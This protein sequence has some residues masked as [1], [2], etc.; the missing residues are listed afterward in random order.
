MLKVGSEDAFER[1]YTQRFREFAGRF[2]EFV[3]YERDR[4]ARDI[5]LHL[6]H[7]RADGEVL[8]TA[9][10]WFQLKGITKQK[11]SRESFDRSTQ[12]TV[13]LKVR[14]LKYWY[15]QPMPTFLSLY[16]ESADLF[17]VLNLQ[18]Y[19]EERWGRS[20]LQL[21]QEVAS[22]KVPRGSV[23]DSQAFHLILMENDVKAWARALAQDEESTRLCRRDYRLI[24]HLGTARERA[25]IHRARIVDWQSKTR[26]EI[27]IE[28]RPAEKDRDW[29]TL[30]QHWQSL[31]APGDLERMYPYLELY[32]SGDE[33]G[34]N[35]GEDESWVPKLEFANGDIVTGADCAG[36]YFEYLASVRLNPLGKTLFESVRALAGIGLVEINESMSE[37]I[38]VAPWEWRSV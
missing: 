3:L 2:G 19:T 4:G 25:A 11:L 23:L 28:E 15:L 24:W 14:H 26:G 10:C 36:E 8:S 12:A 20:I 29:H 7:R 18:K 21:H 22:V 5:G 27:H 1:R 34:S 17:L 9:L 31:A 32:A 35:R 38:S 30:R 33:D 16:I 6:T 37:W 13:A